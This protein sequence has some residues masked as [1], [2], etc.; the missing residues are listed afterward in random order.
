LICVV[1]AHIILPMNLV[2]KSYSVFF[3]VVFGL[4]F[5]VYSLMTNKRSRMK[6]ECRGWHIILPTD[7][8]SSVFAGALLAVS[9]FSM[10]QW[11]L[12]LIN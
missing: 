6:L 1:D 10:S 3:F 9:H 5:F 11:Y 7:L 2:M 12:H 8:L 4:F